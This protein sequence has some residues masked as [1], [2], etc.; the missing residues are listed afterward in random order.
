[1]HISEA[2]SYMYKK[3]SCC[4]DTVQCL[5]FTQIM[6]FTHVSTLRCKTIFGCHFTISHNIHSYTWCHYYRFINKM[7]EIVQS[8]A[9]MWILWMTSTE[10]WGIS[11]DLCEAVENTFE[12]MI[13]WSLRCNKERNRNIWICEPYSNNN[14]NRT[15]LRNENGRTLEELVPT[16]SGWTYYCMYAF[17]GLRYWT[18]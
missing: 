12:T 4:R 7:M 13:D 8:L 18:K 1:M 5:L 11:R 10:E 17:K 14:L 16:C 2:W 9:C 3:L 6:L 15:L